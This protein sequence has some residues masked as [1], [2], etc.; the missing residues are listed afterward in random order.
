[1]TTV[2]PARSA[3][4][5]AAAISRLLL[6]WPCQTNSHESLVA[7]NSVFEAQL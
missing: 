2:N 4:P 7:R 6:G 1:V 3:A 5:H